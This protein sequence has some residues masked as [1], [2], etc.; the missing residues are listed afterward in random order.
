[1]SSSTCCCAGSSGVRRG[2]ILENY[3]HL[4]A[5]QVATTAAADYLALLTQRA[6]L[7][8]PTTLCARPGVP[9][10]GGW[11]PVTSPVRRVT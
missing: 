3:P 8:E 11:W 4:P 9:P 6:C 10:E 2:W 1:M 5:A 7:M